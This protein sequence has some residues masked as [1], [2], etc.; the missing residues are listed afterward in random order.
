MSIGSFGS[1][2]SDSANFGNGNGGGNGIAGSESPNGKEIVGSLIENSQSD[3]LIPPETPNP[4]DLL[5]RHFV[6]S[7]AMW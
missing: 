3:A 5:G 7:I 1:H 6:R 4:M 2:E